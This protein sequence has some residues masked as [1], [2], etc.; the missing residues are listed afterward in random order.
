MGRQGVVVSGPFR[1]AWAARGWENG[2]LGYPTSDAYLWGG[3]LVQ[4]FQRGSLRM[5]NGRVY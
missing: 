4:S 5:R 3:G 1:D 2:P